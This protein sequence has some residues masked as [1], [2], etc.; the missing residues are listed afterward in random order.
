MISDMLCVPVAGGQA[1][2]EMHLKQRFL[3]DDPVP[4][5]R[6]RRMKHTFVV[7]D[8]RQMVVFEVAARASVTRRTQT[9]V[10]PR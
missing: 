10:K 6:K 9:L 4:Y 5:C 2:L 3:A 1:V 8:E 7:R